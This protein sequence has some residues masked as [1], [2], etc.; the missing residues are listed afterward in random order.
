MKQ[1]QRCKLPPLCVTDVPVELPIAVS[2]K[3]VRDVLKSELSTSVPVANP[4]IAVASSGNETGLT[5]SKGEETHQQTN[6]ET[7]Q[8]H[9]DPKT[10]N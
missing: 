2:S 10:G 1:Q 6:T 3:Q 4:A 9:E 5:Q 8:A 7:V